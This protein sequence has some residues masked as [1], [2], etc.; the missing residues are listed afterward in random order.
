MD[1]SR[2]STISEEDEFGNIIYQL[3][4]MMSWPQCVDTLKLVEINIY[5]RWDFN[6]KKIYLHD[7]LNFHMVIIPQGSVCCDWSW[8]CHQMETFSV[9]LAL[10]AGNSPVTGEFPSQRPMT[11]SFVFFNS[12]WTNSRANNG[13]A[14]DLRHHHVHYDVIVMRHSAKYIQKCLLWW[15]F[16][17]WLFQ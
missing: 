1:L 4:A 12:T 8:W 2:N 17:W 11:R 15:V 9:L 13:E 14:G 3:A 10:C 5:G 6:Y 16:R 7:D